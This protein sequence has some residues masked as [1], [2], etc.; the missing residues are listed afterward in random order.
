MIAQSIE[1]DAI[2]KQCPHATG[3][4][5]VVDMMQWFAV[6]VGGALGATCRWWLSTRIYAW[7]GTGFPF[8][9][10][11]V[12]VLGSLI[13]GVAVALLLERL[14]LGANWR[15]IWIIGFLGA[16]TTFST[17]SMETVNLLEQGDVFKAMLN[18]AIS[19]VVCVGAAWLGL[20]LGRSV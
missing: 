2:S 10:L 13:M 11:A 9:T 17:F 8:G 1:S 12:N 16:F 18:V 15:A 4:A 14:S 3:S 7:L 20:I 19:V 6:A 5:E